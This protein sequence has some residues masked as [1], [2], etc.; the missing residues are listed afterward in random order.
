MKSKLL[1]VTLALF[2]MIQVG[3]VKAQNPFDGQQIVSEETTWIFNDDTDYPVGNV[4]TLTEKKKLYTRAISS[5]SRNFTFS[6][7]DEQQLSFSDGYTVTV[8]KVA[9][10]NSVTNVGSTIRTAGHTGTS[11]GTPVFAFNAS[12]AGTCYVLIQENETSHNTDYRQRIYFGDGSNAVESK[13]S[14]EGA[15][16]LGIEEMKFTSE[17]AGAFFIGAT[18][19]KF[20]IYAIRFVP[21]ATKADK[22]V[23]IGA[24]G[25]ATFADTENKKYITPSGLS[26]YIAKASADNHSVELIEATNLKNTK[27]Y[28]LKGTPY[29]NY[30]LTIT[31]EGVSEP[32]GS[33]LVR[34]NEAVTFSVDENGKDGSNKYN[35]ILAAD[36]DVAKFFAVANE[37]TLAK[38]K[39]WLQTATQLTPGDAGARGISIIFDDNTTNIKDVISL[40]A[41]GRGDYYN[42]AGQRVKQPT[43]GLYIVNGKKIMIK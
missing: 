14:S 32:S 4:T 11:D 35:Y 33:Q 31:G 34:A 19:S 28:I 37:S 10:S 36:G 43:K 9:S 3:E 41:K 17:S 27:P 8:N 5:G 39:A 13:N 42:L 21:T 30:K 6:T 29:T 23:Y 24:T 40:Q 18:K 26:A 22:I 16:A 38:G 20:K 25:Y 1:K 2:A 7:V 15:G 12:V